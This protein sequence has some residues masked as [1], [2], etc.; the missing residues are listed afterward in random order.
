MKKTWIEPEMV[1]TIV[2]GGTPF[3]TGEASLYIT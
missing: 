2:S 1:V 3:Y